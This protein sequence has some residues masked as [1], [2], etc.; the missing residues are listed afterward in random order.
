MMRAGA[1]QAPSQLFYVLSNASKP[2]DVEIVGSGANGSP[3][4]LN[5]FAQVHP[6]GPGGSGGKDTLT[7]RLRYFAKCLARIKTAFEAGTFCTCARPMHN[8]HCGFP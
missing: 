5:M 2:G 7:D 3:G 1:G 8:A 4:V 6:S